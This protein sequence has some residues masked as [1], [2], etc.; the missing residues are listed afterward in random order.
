M[1]EK[2]TLRT[3]SLQHTANSIFGLLVVLVLSK[4]LPMV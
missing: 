4:A 2:E 3:W 1:T